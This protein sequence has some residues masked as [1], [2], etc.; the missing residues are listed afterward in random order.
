MHHFIY[1][2]KDT[3]I[4]N[5][6]GLETKNF[7]LDEILQVG[8]VNSPKPYLS[9]TKDYF[10]KN[11]ILTGKIELFTGKFV[12]SLD[13]EVF[14]AT[15]S[16]IGENLWFSSSYFNGIVDGEP[17]EISGSI[18]GSEVSGMVSG[19]I[20]APFFIGEFNG[21]ISGTTGCL[22]GTGS[23]VDVRV[24]DNWKV[25]TTQ[26]VYRSL[27]KFNLNKVS[28]SVANGEITDPK[29]Y[30]NIKICNEFQ[31]PLTYTI[32]ASSVSQDWDKGIGYLSD[33]GSNEGASWIYRNRNNGIK[34]ND[35]I[36]TEPKSAINFIDNPE[37][38]PVV[39]SYG[40]GIW[41]PED[42]CKQ[43]FSHQSADIK[44]DV[45][46]I[47]MKWI[48][49]DIPNYGFIIYCSD[50]LIGTSYGFMLKFFSKN[51]N[52]IY[53]PY[54]D[55][56]WN[57]ATF[58]TESITTGSVEIKTEGP[59]ISASISS[60]SSIDGEFSGSF[61][62]SSV[63]NI[64][65][66][67]LTASNY[68]FTFDETI[69]EFT[70]S[71][72]GSFYT[73]VQVSGTI[74]GSDL[75]F[76]VDY[77]SGSID[78]TKDIIETVG[79]V[80]GIDIDGVIEGNL[81][82]EL[83]FGEYEG[84]LTS[85]A[86]FLSGY[87]TG[88]YLDP[89]YN[90]FCGFILATGSSGNIID[91]PVIGSACGIITISQSLISGSCGK[92]FD[93]NLVTGSFIDGVYSGSNFTAYYVNNQLVN[94]FL[95]G[96]WTEAA[97]LGSNINIAIPSGYEPYALA[98]IH[99]KYVKGTALGIYT[100]SGSNSA[101][102]VG[103]F[104]EGAQV[105]VELNL[106]LNGSIYTS[107]YSYTSSIELITNK[108]DNLDAGGQ[109]SINL[110]NLQ[111]VYRSG[112]IIKI[113][114]FGRK[115]FPHKSFGRSSQQEQYTIPEI[116]PR[117]SFYAIKDNQTGEIVVP[118]DNYTQISCEHPGGNYFYLDTTGLPQERYYRILIQV[119]DENNTYTIDT[120]K[121]FKIV[122][123]GSTAESTYPPLG[124]PEIMVIQL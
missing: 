63:F 64:A 109:F 14:F 87:G 7:G 55:V 121:I 49:G 102:F 96:R 26:H 110:Q 58:V 1:P 66:N 61:T 37:L 76:T 33:G 77:F 45:T 90:K 93:A 57:D 108:F 41:H 81:Y 46:P 12:G 13:G 40:G 123:G 2:E 118:A 101:S 74:T 92:T 47:V 29:F 119:S 30:L 9:K 3:F 79:D 39:F 86:V 120:G 19:S 115:K 117:T 4:T 51:T 104:T 83:P 8:T 69:K 50:E 38:L 82:S 106:Q 111:P 100:I 99:G 94:A 122:R 17:L 32:Y 25:I 36:L 52:T 88:Y 124:A 42:T 62:G 103:K 70:G 31:I 53:S 20:I 24:E 114:V 43:D 84:L 71:F 113:F 89:I 75:T 34:W 22:Q 97:I 15:G 23:G 27:L 60:G 10:Y 67:Y 56:A 21:E 68:L 5:R 6:H 65:K 78:E 112:D 54:L 98:H 48:S 73:E 95:T 44:M 107:S 85:S 18:S 35:P 59:W 72:T 80:S 91:S 28:E 116:L 11:Q 105:G 16:I